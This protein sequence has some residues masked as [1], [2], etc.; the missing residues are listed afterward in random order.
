MKV[1]STVIVHEPL[2]C[3]SVISKGNRS[4]GCFALTVDFKHLLF[5]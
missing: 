3:F 2:V 1:L 5:S 4:K